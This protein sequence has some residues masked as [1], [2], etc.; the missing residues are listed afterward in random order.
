MAL[1][2]KPDKRLN[3][4]EKHYDDTIGSEYSSSGADQAEAFANDPA[5]STAQSLDDAE[6]QATK[7]VK[8]LMIFVIKKTREH[9][10]TKPQAI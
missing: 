7:E 5:N 3:P 4:Y 1:Q 2:T 9:G 8:I 6:A 10:V